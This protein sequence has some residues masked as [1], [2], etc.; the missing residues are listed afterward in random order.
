[1]TMEGILGRKVGMTQIYDEQ[2]AAVPVT[3]V[4]AGPCVVV[5]RKSVARDGYDAVQIGLV[6]AKTPKHVNKPASGHFTKAGVEPVRHL[7][8]I[9]VEAGTEAAAG[10]E[11]K[12]SI[13]EADQLVDVVATSK[14]K[15][16]QGVMKRHGFGG[17]RATH[18]S[19]FH[20][21]PG[22]IG[23][24]S[25]PS[26]VFPGTRLPG[27]MGNKRITT[28]N[29]RVVKVDEER[30]LLFIRGAVPGPRGGYVTIKRAK[31]G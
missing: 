8:E 22:S 25:D 13:F 20:R 14:G 6:E 16:F 10:D 17:G 23:Q 3:L 19:M 21:A 24:A 31:K 27:Q 2:G 4:K 9:G 7:A 30:D 11:V 28:K 26:R 12:V 18:G 1:M 5:Q 15:G 29:P